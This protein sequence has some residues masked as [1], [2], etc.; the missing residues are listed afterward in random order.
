[1]LNKNQSNFGKKPET[2][3]HN[4]GAN[5][6]NFHTQK[7]TKINSITYPVGKVVTKSSSYTQKTCKIEYTHPQISSSTS[8][9]MNLVA[10]LGINSNSTT[11]LKNPLKSQSTVLDDIKVIVVLKEKTDRQKVNLLKNLLGIEVE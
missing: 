10:N 7:P 4:Y 2:I 3:S 9:N 6:R 1:M 8:L 5:S 11:P